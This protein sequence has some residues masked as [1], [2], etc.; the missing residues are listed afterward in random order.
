MST[1]RNMIS[2]PSEG[3]IEDFI[4]SRAS[5]EAHSRWLQSPESR[6]LQRDRTAVAISFL[7]RTL[8]LYR[9]VSIDLRI[10]QHTSADPRTL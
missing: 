7:L 2:S 8:S 4:S 1:C 3:E 9:G 10:A 5:P 6:L